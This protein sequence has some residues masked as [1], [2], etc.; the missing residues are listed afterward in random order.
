MPAI[1]LQPRGSKASLEHYD[2]TIENNIRFDDVSNLIPQEYHNQLLAIYPEREL[3][4]WGVTPGGAKGSN[5]PKW[6]RIQP[7]DITLFTANNVIVASAVVTLK[8]RSEALAKELWGLDESGNTWEYI[9]FTDQVRKLAISVPEFNKAVGYADNFIVRGFSVLDHQK[10]EAAI[11]AFD[12]ESEVYYPES[13]VAE[14]EK[15]FEFD[16]TLDKTSKTTIRKE[17]AALR[18]ILFHNRPTATCCICGNEYP[19][20]LLV[21]A[22]IKKR[23]KCTLEEKKD[24]HHVAAPMCKFGCD[25]LFER[26]YI[27]VQEGVVEKIKS[28]AT[29]K[30]DSYLK[31]LEGRDC[32]AWRPQ[33]QKY[34]NWHL[35]YHS[36]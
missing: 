13:A 26:G 22:H 34:F 7:G 6:D 10:S 21:A 20:E 9:Y 30:V 36:Q 24:L 14:A 11:V 19:V 17:Q 16:T 8:L 12:L 31:E 5:I 33:T 25:E 35:T 32:S 4:V 15:A 3:K 27:R 29:H 23:N 1:I 2:L 18:K 28:G